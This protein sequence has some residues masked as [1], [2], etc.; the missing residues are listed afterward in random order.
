MSEPAFWHPDIS[1]PLCS[2]FQ[3]TILD[4]QRCYKLELNDSSGKGKDNE[5][6]FLLDYQEDLALQLPSL[7]EVH[8]NSSKILEVDLSPWV[9]L[10]KEEAKIHINTISPY[11]DFGGGTFK[12]VSVKRMSAKKDF[13]QMPLEDREC[14]VEQFEDC[15]TRR[16]LEECKCVPWEL[17]GYQVINL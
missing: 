5:L 3:P 13:L 11:K 4:G 9:G 1:F 14:E 6:M 7:K 17:P 16:L 15:R 2:A 12:M 8:V 10:D